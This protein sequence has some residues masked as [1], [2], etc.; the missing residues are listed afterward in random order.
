MCYV[1]DLF[2]NYYTYLFAISKLVHGSYLVRGERITNIRELFANICDTFANGR[3]KF[4]NVCKVLSRV[5][6][7]LL[8]LYIC[9]YT[10]LNPENAAGGQIETFQNV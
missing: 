6:N 9:I 3:D 10:G 8:V 4:T 1:R 7:I 2:H 5:Y